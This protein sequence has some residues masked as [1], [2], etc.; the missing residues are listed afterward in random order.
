MFQKTTLSIACASVLMAVSPWVA[1]DVTLKGHVNR[2]I[3][4]AD[5]GVDSE[6]FFVDNDNSSTRIIID[7]RHPLNDD[8]TVGAQFEVEQQSQASN[9][10]SMGSYPNHNSF[11]ERKLETYFMSKKM[12]TLWLGQGDTASKATSEVDLSG[13]AVASY[14]ETGGTGG[15]LQWRTSDGSKLDGNLAIRNVTTHFDGLGRNDRV[16]YD[17]PKLA[18]FMLSA[19]AVTAE[20]YDVALRYDNDFGFMK[21]AGAL[22]YADFGTTPRNFGGS[23]AETQFNGSISALFDFGLNLTLSAGTTDFESLSDLTDTLKD[24]LEEDRERDQPVNYWGKL[25]YQFS[26]LPLGKTAVSIEYGETLDLA[27]QGD[28]YK[29]YGASL[30]QNIDAASTE[31]FL[32]YQGFELDRDHSV[33]PEDIFVV[34][35]GARV[36]F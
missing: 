25:G 3:M 30:V 12:G 8:V 27:A 23:I 6:T 13:T 15:A 18:G 36:K 28:T 22:A 7:A 17:T 35:G 5:D 26:A 19:S 20:Q 14:A 31:L 16:R 10:V 4:Y 11:R 29:T 21:L 2:A 32:H 33:N 24:T 34:M 9:E 1:A